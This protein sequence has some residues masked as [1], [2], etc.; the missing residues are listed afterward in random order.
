MEAFVC[1]FLF[2]F[3]EILKRK[4]LEFSTN[5]GSMRQQVLVSQALA[6]RLQ[7]F[8]P[9]THGTF[10][11]HKQSWACLLLLLFPVPWFTYRLKWKLNLKVNFSSLKTKQK[12]LKSFETEIL[13]L[14]SMKS[15]FLKWNFFLVVKFSGFLCLA[16]RKRFSFFFLCFLDGKTRKTRKPQ[17]AFMLFWAFVFKTEI[18]TNQKCCKNH[19]ECSGEFDSI[20]FLSF[21]GF[22]LWNIKSF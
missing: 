14:K 13:I 18:K 20:N 7:A 19:V 2:F 15:L 4:I 22:L 16:K 5:N 21:C 6:S 17:T 12:A 11:V 10:Q 1:F 8:V 3:C 9:S